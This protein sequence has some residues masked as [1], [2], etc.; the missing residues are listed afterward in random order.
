MAPLILLAEN[1]TDFPTSE[2][3]VGIDVGIVPYC[4]S[5]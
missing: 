2:S 5:K 4:F 3:I 1:L